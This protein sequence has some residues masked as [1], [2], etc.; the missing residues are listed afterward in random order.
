MKYNGLTTNYFRECDV[1]VIY[2]YTA[3]SFSLHQGTST[4]YPQANCDTEKMKCLQQ[5]YKWIKC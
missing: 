3:F 1:Y 2:M 5:E 4:N